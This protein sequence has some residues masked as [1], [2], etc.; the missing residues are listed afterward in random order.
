VITESFYCYDCTSLTTLEGAPQKVTE[1]FYCSD[2]TSLTSLKG[3]PQE[4]RSFYG[5]NCTSL[6]SLEG[7]P[8]EVTGVFNCTGKNSLNPIHAQVMDDYYED[9]LDWPTAYRF[10]HRPKLAK[11]HSLGLI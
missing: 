5:Y 4:V 2:C 6:T 10:I 3:G 7:A 8:Q 1:D 9:M 11:A